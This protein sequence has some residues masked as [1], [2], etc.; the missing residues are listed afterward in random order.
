MQEVHV[1]HIHI[2][3]YH[4]S[5]N[6]RDMPAQSKTLLLQDPT[7]Q[8]KTLLLLLLCSTYMCS[9]RKPTPQPSSG[10]LITKIWV[11]GFKRINLA[12]YYSNSCQGNASPCL[13]IRP[14]LRKRRVRSE[15]EIKERKERKNCKQLKF[16]TRI[17]ISTWHKVILF[18]LLSMWFHHN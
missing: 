13:P 9:T 17:G 1:A 11:R 7:S 2:T 5:K 14:S 15:K 10:I 6:F 12:S 16:N 3:A 18:V 8:S 4:N